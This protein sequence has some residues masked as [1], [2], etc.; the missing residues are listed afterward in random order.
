MPS[1]RQLVELIRTKSEL[2]I[3]SDIPLC[4]KDLCAHVAGY[5]IVLKRWEQQEFSELVSIVE[6]PTAALLQYT[7]ESFELLK[8][9]QAEMLGDLKKESQ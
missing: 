6:Y 8:R 9:E 2:I 4:L 7:A 1:N 3:E 5:E